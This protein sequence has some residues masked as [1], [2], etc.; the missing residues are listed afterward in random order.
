MSLITLRSGSRCLFLAALA[1]GVT[2]IGA[3][4]S[5]PAAPPTPAVQ[6][7]P[8][9]TW[10]VVN[11]QS[12]TRDDVDRAYRRSRDSSQPL[13]DEETLAAKLSLLNDLITEN[14]LVAKAQA[15]KLEV[16]ESE[17]DTA[18]TEAKKNIP[19]DAFQQELTKRNVTPADM[20]E[21]LRRSLLTQKVIDREVGSKIN[22]SDKDVTDFF[23]ANR[24]QFN[25]AEEAYHLAQIVVTPTREAQPTNRT[26]DDATTP[27]A[28]TTKVNMLMER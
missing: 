16:S 2:S 1:V 5:K 22:I 25:V 3:C 7:V 11:G 9:S 21:G 15:L 14:L 13:S 23:N 6:T 18:Y 28:A 27:Q 19:D 12:I 20:R 26:G 17:I 24:S 10:A 8:D 4:R